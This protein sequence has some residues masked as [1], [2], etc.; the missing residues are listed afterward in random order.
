MTTQLSQSCYRFLAMGW[1]ASIKKL[2]FIQQ[3]DFIAYDSINKKTTGMNKNVLLVNLVGDDI[4][5]HI[6]RYQQGSIQDKIF[7]KQNGAVFS[8]V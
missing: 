4:Q 6:H 1:P 7:E 8:M 3:A 2:P 5:V